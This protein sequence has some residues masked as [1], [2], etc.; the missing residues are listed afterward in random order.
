[1]NDALD[2]IFDR[3]DLASPV[4]KPWVIG[5]N[6]MDCAGKT[7]FARAL[8]TYLRAAGRLVTE[9]HIDDYNDMVVQKRVYDA[10]AEGQSRETLIDEFYKGS[11]DYDRAATAIH[12]ASAGGGTVVVEGVFLFKEPLAPLFDYKIYLD[13]RHD[14]GRRRYASRKEAEGDGRHLAVFEE[15]WVPA[16]V[17]YV[18][19][20]Q[21]ENLANLIVDNNEADCPGILERLP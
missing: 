19:E 10:F 13:I 9:L 15:L 5:V 4:R 16:H 21:P 6:G 20:F 7:W 3:I 8:T 1:M 12:E 17:R 11:V 2:K 14:V 18:R